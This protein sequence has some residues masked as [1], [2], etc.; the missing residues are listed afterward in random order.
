MS[1]GTSPLT[2]DFNNGLGPL[3]N[4]WNVDTSVAGE[5]TLRGSSAV[6]EWAVG[7]SSGHG[8]GTYTIDAKATGSV[9][10]PGIILWPGNN[11]W[12]GQ[13]ID[14][15]EI[16][17]DGSGRQYGTVHWNAN[18]SDAYVAQIYDGVS[19]NQWHQY[20]MVWEPG[21][22]TFKVDGQ[23]KATVTDHVPADFDHGG[24]N[25]TIGFMNTSNSTSLT[26]GHVDYQPLGSSN[27]W[28]PPA[29]TDTV[30]TVVDN[31]V[32]TAASSVTS[33]VSDTVDWNA[34]AAQVYANHEA[35]GHWFL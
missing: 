35:T 19:G 22:I 12:P 17:P 24:M 7:P 18:G 23:T 10:G 5:I 30:K 16:T 21:K 1:N 13:E 11:Q 27:T 4:A 9:P 20:Q 8:Y 3:G 32:N 26:V 25:N 6:M 33:T 29:V 2:I 31:V 14:M 15:L 28:T 34:I